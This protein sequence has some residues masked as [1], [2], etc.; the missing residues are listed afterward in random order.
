[1][2]LV[3]RAIRKTST[4]SAVWNIVEGTDERYRNLAV[5]PGVAAKRLSESPQDRRHE[6]LATRHLSEPSIPLARPK[7]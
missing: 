1:M 7:G 3:E 6:G 5:M 4:T 2:P